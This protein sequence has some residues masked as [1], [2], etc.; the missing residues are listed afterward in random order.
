MQEIHLLIIVQGKGHPQTN[1]R[2]NRARETL[3]LPTRVFEASS[4]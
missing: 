1:Q 2:E 4:Q 3:Q